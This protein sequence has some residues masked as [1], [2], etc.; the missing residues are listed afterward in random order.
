LAG[1]ATNISLLTELSPMV[2]MV[3]NIQVRAL[4]A[5]VENLDLRKWLDA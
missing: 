3:R 1:V 5:A 4:A 2:G